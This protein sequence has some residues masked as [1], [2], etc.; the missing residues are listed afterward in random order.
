MHAIVILLLLYAMLYVA[1]LPNVLSLL[2][3][4][5]AAVFYLKFARQGN[6]KGSG[7]EGRRHRF[8]VV[9][10]AHDEEA[11]IATT[12]RSCLAINYSGFEVL[13]IADNCG[14]GTALRAEEAGARVLERSDPA[15]KS[16]GHAIEYL[17]DWLDR[18]G[19]LAT[20]DALVVVDA[21]STVAPNLLEQFSVGLDEGSEWMQC[22]DCVGNADATWRTRLMAYGMALF[23]GIS[24]AGRQALGLSGGLRGNGMCISVAGLKRVPWH[25]HGLVEDQEY[26]WIVR[27][28]G[29]RIDFIK[30]TAVY[31]TMLREGGAPLANQRRRWEF[32]RGDVRR[33]MLGPLLRSPHVS[34]REKVAG[35]VEIT[36]RPTGQIAVAYV[37][38][39]GLLA[40][41]LPDMIARDATVALALAGVAHAL[42]TV[43]LLVHA[44][45]PFLASLLP[46]R[47]LLSLVYFP[48]YICWK[49]L[50]MAQ[51]A[52]ERWIATDRESELPHT[53]YPQHGR[54]VDGKTSP[55]LNGC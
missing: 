35:A 51:G 29:G 49:L 14:D 32:G 16:K 36:S 23:N 41:A 18:S 45:S 21:D 19:E 11:N 13:V 34:L 9:I 54:I 38:L 20:L 47:Y 25:A 7:R 28:A 40:Y 53:H 31:A 15:R 39:T 5:V 6:V 37:I 46:W 12:V 24:L 42:A 50:V 27:I 1:I 30:G 33:K 3:T 55:P 48:Y 22:Y 44:L 10:P 2:V 26:S 43:A 8:L 17:I 4:S 52:P